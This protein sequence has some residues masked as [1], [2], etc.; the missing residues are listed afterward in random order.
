MRSKLIQIKEA[1]ELLGV[2]K[3]TLRNW[4]KE[5]KLIAYR[6]PI[7]NYR[8]YRSEDIDGILE[9][10]GPKEKLKWSPKTKLSTAPKEKDT[11]KTKSYTLKVLHLKD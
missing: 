2:S 10:I 7:N 1:A 4:D 8:V 9:K 6:H 11:Q 3:L 5:G